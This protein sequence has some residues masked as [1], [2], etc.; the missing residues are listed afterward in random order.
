MEQSSLPQTESQPNTEDFSN[1]SLRPFNLSDIDDFMVWATDE[2]V[3]HFCTWYPYTSKEDGLNHIKNV[4]IPHP[5]FM[6]ICLNSR[7][8]GGIL[9]TTY[10]GND[11]CRGEIGYFLAYK[12]W[13]KGI[14][15]RAVKMAAEIILR[16]HP[17]MERLEA[18]VDLQNVGSQKVLEKVGFERECV[19]RKYL[20]IKGKTRD[21][22]L[23]S[24][25]STYP[26]L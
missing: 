26:L 25:L 6:A 17:E 13:G 16:Q 8:I 24:L 22:V 12:F 23:F 20:I 9:L 11:A 7:P 5:W 21:M 18:F 10:S 3:A 14:G 15:T 2:K 19:L 4:I 1:I